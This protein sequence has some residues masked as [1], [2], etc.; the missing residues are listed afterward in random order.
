MTVR[1]GI[2]TPETA[3][4]AQTDACWKRAFADQKEGQDPI[5]ARWER[6]EADELDATAAHVLDPCNT[7]TAPMEVG[8]GSAYCRN[9]RD[10][11]PQG[12]TVTRYRQR[13]P[14]HG[15]R[16]RQHRAP[17][18]GGGCRCPGLGG[19]YRRYNP[20]SKQSGKD[21][22]STTGHAAHAGDEECRHGIQLRA[23]GGR[24]LCSNAATPDR[25]CGSSSRSTNA[26]ARACEAY[27]RGILTLDRCGMVGGRMWSVQHVNVGQGGQAVVAGL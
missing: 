20:S 18:L 15:C 14:G 2:A 7:V 16:P 25:E 21:A 5:G 22:G 4:K 8:R 23:Q 19:G 10:A 17:R 12:G 1:T 26:A 11:D 3:I 6:L 24:Y 27:Q 13:Q 9:S